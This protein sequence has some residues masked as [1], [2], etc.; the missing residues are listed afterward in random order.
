MQTDEL[1][2]KTISFLRFPLIVCVAFIHVNYVNLNPDL[3]ALTGFRNVSHLISDQL[4]WVSV[5][6]FFFIS[7]FLFFRQGEFNKGLYLDKLKKRARTLLVPY[8]LWNAF[9]LLLLFVLQ[10]AKPG[11]TMGIKKQMVDFVWSDWLLSFWNVSLINGI[12][13]VACGP[14]AE[15]FWFIQD[16]MVL[17]VLSPVIWFLIRKLKVGFVLVVLVLS[18]FGLLPD[19]VGF[20]PVALSFFVYGAYFSIAR[21]SFIRFSRYAFW[22][23]AL[24]FVVVYVADALFKVQLPDVIMTL[25]SY[26]LIIVVVA[27]TARFIE[28]GSWRPVKLLAD[29]SF[30]VFAF[31]ELP[32]AAPLYFIK[33][34]TIVPQN[35]A[36]ALCLYF[37]IPVVAV[38]FSVGLYY[39]LK[40]RMPAFTSL[41]TGGR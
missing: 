32:I 33:H 19:I 9:Y 4:A 13:H 22:P 30:F 37:L 23:S 5:P 29:S 38:A 14:L 16:L 8:I 17:V 31:H 26:A 27:V 21:R 39:C 24:L 36:V 6:T 1:Q 41:I 10:T 3:Y 18:L 15:Q 2:S 28:K 35:D 20:S 34:K 7:G 25:Q 12:P 11:F 40:K